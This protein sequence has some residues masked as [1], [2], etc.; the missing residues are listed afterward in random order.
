MCSR[1]PEKIGVVLWQEHPTL[2][3]LIKMVTSNRFRFPTV[4]CDEDQRSEMKSAEQAA[5]E[6]VRKR[7]WWCSLCKRVV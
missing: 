2:R 6:K 7:E 1:S 3:A 4:D 5:R